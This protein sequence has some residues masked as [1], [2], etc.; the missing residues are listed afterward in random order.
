MAKTFEGR[1]VEAPTGGEKLFAAPTPKFL[2]MHHPNTWDLVETDDGYEILPM[3][4]K[5]QLIPGLNG[6]KHRAGGGVDSTAARAAFMDQGWVFIE[7]EKGGDGGYLREY[8]GY[9]GKVYVDK[10][11]K[12]R[13]LGHGSRARVVWDVDLKG[14]NDFRRSLMDSGDIGR[15]DPAAL[16]WKIELLD[17]RI[18]RKIKSSHIPKIAKDLEVAQAKQAALNEVKS[19]SKTKVKTKKA[20][21]KRKTADARV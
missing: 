16:N 8:D 9:L 14:Y 17:K 20:A 1:S 10:W 7:N 12:P 15:P 4:T 13:S 3:L 11:S 5:F 18:G 2:F 6:I 19:T 21:T